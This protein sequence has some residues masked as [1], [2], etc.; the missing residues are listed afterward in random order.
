MIL[1]RIGPENMTLSS[2]GHIDATGFS[3]V[4]RKYMSRRNIRNR[5]IILWNLEFDPNWDCE[6]APQRFIYYEEDNT[7]TT[8]LGAKF[9][10]KSKIKLGI[11]EAEAGTEISFGVEI[12]SDD[13]VIWAQTFERNEFFPLNTTNGGCGTDNGWRKHACYEGWITIPSKFVN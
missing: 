9:T 8:K 5:S 12:K 10:L 2:S 7:S 6:E 4:V 11:V 3:A 1:G 13:D